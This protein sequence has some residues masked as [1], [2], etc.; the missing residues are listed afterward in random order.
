MRAVLPKT[1]PKV[2]KNSTA[3]KQIKKHWQLYL[4]IALPII[5]LIVFQYIPMFGVQ[6]AF[7]D[8][9]LASGILGSKWVG[10]KHFKNFISSYQFSRLMINTIGLSL[11]QIIAGF[12]P[13]IILAIALNYCYRGVVKKSVQML[14]YMPYFISTVLVVSM[15]NQILS[16]NGIVNNLIKLFGGTPIQFLAEP[17][18]FKSIYVWS[19][20]WQHTGYSAVIFIAALAS[21]NQELYEAA[22]V[23]GASVIRR[24][25]HID[26]PGILPT[27]VILLIMSTG[28]ILNIGFEKVFLLQ[29]PLNTQASDIISTYVYKIGLVSMQY[30]YSS[31]IGL[32]QSI[33]SLI[34][35]VAVNSISRKFSETS[36]W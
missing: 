2:T 34:L 19:G 18:L 11:Y 8:Y 6:I 15:L 35:L 21:I 16:N 14:T 31:A 9:K 25:W 13:P 5:Y 29:N 32:F 12:A 30:S 20:I 26:I 36:L 1:L 17:I 23:D 24:I 3:M 33:V 27:A 10:L 28:N 7:K 22:I 4:I